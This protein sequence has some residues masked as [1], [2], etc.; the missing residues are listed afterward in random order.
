MIKVAILAFLSG[1]AMGSTAPEQKMTSENA[2]N[3]VRQA[4]ATVRLNE[5]EHEMMKEALSVI[6]KM[7]EEKSSKKKES[8]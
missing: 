4:V 3:L 6:K 5:Q 2:Y 1:I 8:K 7:I